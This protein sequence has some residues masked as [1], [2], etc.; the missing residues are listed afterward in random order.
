MKIFITC[1]PRQL[2]FWSSNGDKCDGRDMGNE[3]GIRENHTKFWWGKV[4][5]TRPLQGLGIKANILTREA[6]DYNVICRRVHATIVTV[7]NKYYIFS[8]C[9]CSLGMQSACAILLSVVCPALQHFYTFSHK[10]HDFRKKLPNT[11]CVFWYSLQ[12]F[13]FK[14]LFHRAFW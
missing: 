14:L 11:K 1:T 10:W 13:F 12:L 3:Q 6:T 8:E 9:I 4:W 5:E 7:D 2:L